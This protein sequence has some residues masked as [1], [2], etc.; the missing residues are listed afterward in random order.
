M[1]CPASFS[2]LLLVLALSSPGRTCSQ[3]AKVPPDPAGQE[4]AEQGF[5]PAA[6]GLRGYH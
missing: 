6:L 1:N 5:L 4:S 3:K 2:F